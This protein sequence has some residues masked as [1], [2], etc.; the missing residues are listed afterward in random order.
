M[1]L[2]LISQNDNTNYD[3]FD[4][5]IVAA[6]T[7]DDARM[8]KPCSRDWGDRWSSWARSPDKVS[9]EEIGTAKD[10]T[11]RGVILASFNAG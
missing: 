7:E 1:R 6:E 5:A 10:G 3:T 2:W 9:V 11:E 8:I 4:S